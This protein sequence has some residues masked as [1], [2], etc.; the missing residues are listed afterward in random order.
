MKTQGWLATSS[1]ETSVSWVQVK[2]H[3]ASYECAGLD[4]VPPPPTV[5]TPKP[6]QGP[7]SSQYVSALVIGTP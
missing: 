3:F 5:R 2:P 1:S 4:S 6:P 7:T